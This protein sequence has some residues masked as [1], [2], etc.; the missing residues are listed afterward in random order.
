MIDSSKWSGHRGGPEVRAGQGDRQ[1]DQPQGRRGG[2]PR[3]RR[4]LVRRYG[5]GVVVMAFDEH[6]PGRHG[7]A[8]GRD[9]PARLQAARRARSGFDPHDII[10]DPN[11]LAVAHRASRST[12]TT[13]STSSRRR[14]SSRQ[15]LPGREDLAAACRNVSFSFRGND[16]VREAMHSAF[17]Y[18]AI[19]RRHGHGHRQRRA[20]RR[21]RGDRPGAAGARRG[22]AV[23]PPARRDRAARRASPR[24][25]RARARRRKLDARAWRDAHRRGAALARAGQ[26]HR[27]LHRG[28]RRGGAPEVRAAARRSSRGR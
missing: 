23:Q 24:R 18:H 9:L 10:F 26:G 7:R 17:L 14:G 12:P 6:G 15:T 3:T 16:V 27:R 5:A 2:V 11:I 13:P 22:R 4:A 20:A 1:L 25:S 8:Q 19:Q 21:L 28:R